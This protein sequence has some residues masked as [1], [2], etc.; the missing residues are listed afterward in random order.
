[1]KKGEKMALWLAFGAI[2]GL[3]GITV[4]LEVQHGSKPATEQTAG[5]SSQ[6]GTGSWV[7]PKGINPDALPEAQG[8]AAKTF[9]VYCVQCHDLP[10][11]AMHSAEE[12]TA[13]VDRMR[14]QMQERRGGMLSRL[15][16]P[17]ERDWETINAYL[18]KHAQKAMDPA[19]TADLDT[20]AGKAFVAACSRCHGTPDPAQ[21]TAREWPR[22]VVRMKSNMTAGGMDPLD[23]ETVQQIIGY[24]QTHGAPTDS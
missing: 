13:V 17:S 21:H 11:P 5:A 6:T 20:P 4:I 7:I 8:P 2:A 10:T 16:V 19:H 3:I 1:M 23:A 24:L 18:A 9:T 15:A 12:W 14:S 22:V